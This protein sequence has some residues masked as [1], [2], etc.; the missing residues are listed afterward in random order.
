[1]CAN[2]YADTK[3]EAFIGALMKFRLYLEIL[4]KHLDERISE[5]SKKIDN[6]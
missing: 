1:M 6:A 4:R 2:E 5:I 3:E